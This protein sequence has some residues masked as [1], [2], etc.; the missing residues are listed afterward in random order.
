MYHV[1]TWNVSRG[2][3]KCGAEGTEMGEIFFLGSVLCLSHRPRGVWFD[4]HALNTDMLL[5]LESHITACCCC[6]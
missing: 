6:M 5:S 3:G 1:G 4:L 2:L